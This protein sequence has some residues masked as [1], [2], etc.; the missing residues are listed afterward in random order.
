[1]QK[2]QG[3]YGHTR[4]IQTT[5][6]TPS[7]STGGVFVWL[8]TNS[9]HIDPGIKTPLR[10]ARRSP[11]LFLETVAACARRCS[12]PTREAGFAECIR[13]RTPTQTLGSFCLL[14][15]DTPTP[16]GE[17]C[18]EP[19]WAVRSDDQSRQ[20]GGRRGPLI[21]LRPG[22]IPRFPAPPVPA[23]L[24]PKAARCYRRTG[25]SGGSEPSIRG[26]PRNTQ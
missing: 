5:P 23:P 6:T 26:S 21:H 18:A 25:G 16:V 9:G 13:W 22:A 24:Q 20:M 19:L 8:L 4:P 14:R 12:R 17:A 2:R 15:S 3:G 1:M 10:N 11:P 7:A